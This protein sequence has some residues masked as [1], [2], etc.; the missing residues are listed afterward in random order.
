MLFSS[1]EYSF[2]EDYDMYLKIDHKM[3]TGS[4]MQHIIFL[5]KLVKRAMNKGI[6]SRN[7]FFGYVPDQPKTTR[8]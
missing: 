8:K 7:P 1:L 5:W 2:I 4:V 6:I 3:A